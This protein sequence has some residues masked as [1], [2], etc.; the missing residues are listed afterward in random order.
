VCKLQVVICPHVPSANC[1]SLTENQKSESISVPFGQVST[2]T[3]KSSWKLHCLE[4]KINPN[5]ALSS[6]IVEVGGETDFSTIFAQTES[7]N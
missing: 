5:W 4:H 2:N 6:N 1:K 7:G 3:G